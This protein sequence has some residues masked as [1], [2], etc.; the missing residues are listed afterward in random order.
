M[1]EASDEEVEMNVDELLGGVRDSLRAQ[2]VFGEP[3]ERDGITVV[4]AAAVRG[5]Q[6]EQSLT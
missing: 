2:M 5:V 3:I 1:L 6:P 4:P